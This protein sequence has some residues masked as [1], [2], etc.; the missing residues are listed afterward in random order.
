VIADDDDDGDGAEGMGG[1]APVNAVNTAGVQVGVA[2]DFQRLISHLGV[3]TLA[4]GRCEL[5]ARWPPPALTHQGQP[6]H[7]DHGSPIVEQGAA[8][9]S[10]AW[11]TS[12][13]SAGTAAG[14]AAQLVGAPARSRRA[15]PCSVVVTSLRLDGCE[16]L[17]VV[18]MG[19]LPLLRSLVVFGCE[20]VEEVCGAPR[21]LRRV[22]CAQLGGLA[23]VDLRGCPGRL[24]APGE[25]G[26]TAV[27]AVVVVLELQGC[28]A[29]REVETDGRVRILQYD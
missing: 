1:G 7:P 6:Q 14:D 4:L 17:R 28:P 22:R 23:R 26:L 3:R 19:A 25:G 11:S 16:G 21:G 12:P 18:D 15:L 8:L 13:G 27:A 2:A 10:L 24:Q 20:A 5:P 29:V 9:L